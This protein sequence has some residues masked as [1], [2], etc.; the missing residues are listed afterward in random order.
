ML[1]AVMDPSELTATLIFD[2]DLNE[3]VFD[4]SK[5]TFTF[6]DIP[7]Q[8]DSGAVI[9]GNV[10]SGPL[11][12]LG[13]LGVNNRVVYDGYPSG[14]FGADGTPVGNFDEPFAANIPVPLS[15]IYSVGNAWI[16]VLFDRDVFINTATKTDF[17]AFV[18]PNQLNVQSIVVVGGDTVRLGISID[19]PSAGP[20]RVTYNGKVD[21]IED[22]GGNDVPLFEIG[23]DTVP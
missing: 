16:D 2:S 11:N 23:I 1:A 20:D 9:D 13:D 12:F 22:G 7:N 15:A 8:F 21:G 18:I 10:I 5:I 14:L 3:S 19:G 4:R 6:E 17:N